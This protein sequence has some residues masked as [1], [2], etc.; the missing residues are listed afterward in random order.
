MPIFEGAIATFFGDWVIGSRISGNIKGHVWFRTSD[1]FSEVPE[2]ILSNEIRS[3]C[4]RT[5]YRFPDGAIRVMTTDQVGSPYVRIKGA[6]I[7]LNIMEIDPDLHFSV[8]GTEVVFD[9]LKEGVPIS[10]ESGPSNH[11]GRLVPH[12][13]GRK[14]YLTYF[15]RPRA[16]KSRALVSGKFKGI[17]KPGEIE[18]SGV[19]YSEITYDRDY[20]AMWQF[21]EKGSTNRVLSS[22]DGN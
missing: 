6:R 16:I 13:G 18:A 4:P 8:T 10:I 20:P 12:G 15:V 1:P 9:S 21:A 2:A 22:N 7:P 14:G 19:Y 3:H 17:V 5:V 11:F